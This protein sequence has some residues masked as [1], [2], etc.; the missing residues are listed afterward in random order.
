MFE[1][2]NDFGCA[3]CHQHHQRNHQQNQ[4]NRARDARCQYLT[5]M[6]HVEFG[7]RREFSLVLRFHALFAIPPGAAAIE[8]GSNIRS[9]DNGHGVSIAQIFYFFLVNPL[10]AKP[11]FSS[12]IM[13]A[14]VSFELSIIVKTYC[15]KI[16]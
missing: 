9:A 11:N 8:V 6:P 5:S 3:I 1:R 4:P 2:S 16:I 13:V 14:I 12:E 7:P 10:K 15:D